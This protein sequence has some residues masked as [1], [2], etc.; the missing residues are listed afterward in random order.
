MLFS[1]LSF[2]SE[3][4]PAGLSLAAALTASAIAFSTVAFSATAANAHDALVES[5]PAD[6][7]T[8]TETT[9]TI[10]LTFNNTIAELGG[11]IQVSPSN[12]EPIEA[13]L[14]AKGKDAFLELPEN[15][16]NDD[17]SVS[18]RVVSSDSHAIE[19]EFA[20]VV[21]DPANVIVEPEPTAVATSESPSAEPTTQESQ[22]ATVTSAEDSGTDTATETTGETEEASST[23]W[24]R[25]AIFGGLGAAVGIVLVVLG[26]KRGRKL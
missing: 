14:T 19:G 16:A 2:R 21:N 10:V 24:G 20:F 9:D 13:D 22:E 26:N 4:R 3:R 1:A 12:G 25:I 6:G 18:W 11:K 17:Y 15:L 5:N 8:L 23:N 7:A